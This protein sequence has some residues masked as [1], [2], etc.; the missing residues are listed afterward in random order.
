VAFSGVIPRIAGF[1]LSR[2]LRNGQVPVSRDR[3]RKDRRKKSRRHDPLALDRLL[4][5]AVQAS[6]KIKA[7]PVLYHYT[8]W[9]GIE[10]ILRSQTFRAY[11][12]DSTNDEAELISADAIIM[13]VA[14]ELRVSA[15]GTARSALT[16]FLEGYPTRKIT[17]LMTV[18]LACFSTARD[19][20]EQWKRYGDR[21]GG[22]C[23]GFRMLDEPPPDTP[24]RG[25]ALIKVDYSENAWRASLRKHFAEV[26]ALLR[27]VPP[28]DLSR[29]LGASAF[30]RIAGFTATGAKQEGWAVEQEFRNVTIVHQGAK[31]P[32]EVDENGR[33]FLP[34]VV[35]ADGKRMALAEMLIGPNRDVDAA[36]QR[37]TALLSDVGYN[38]SDMEYPQVVTS[39]L[40]PLP[41]RDKIND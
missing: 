27:R 20:L 21:G 23:L 37:V 12:H 33:R 4:D 35:R 5:L 24:D 28:T 9:K 25:S 16:L 30:Y 18:Y 40:G 7:P 36:R 11:A 1:Y 29:E 10:E 34:I 6:F 39:A 26:C 31:N 22:V 41:Q 13:E 3:P 2:L 15:R 38:V 14:D 19:D 32:E 8:K 17:K